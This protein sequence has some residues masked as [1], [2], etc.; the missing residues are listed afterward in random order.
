MPG[1]PRR[2]NRRTVLRPRK[3]AE[4]GGFVKTI[5]LTI[6][7]DGTDFFGFQKQTGRE[8]TMPTVQACIEAVFERVAGRR[9]DSKGS[10]RTDRGV[11]AL[12]QVVS[13]QIADGY[14]WRIPA[15]GLK[16]LM[17]KGLPPSIRVRSVDIHDGKFHALGNALGKSYVYLVNYGEPSVFLNRFSWHVR[18]PIDFSRLASVVRWFRGERDWSPFCDGELTRED[19]DDLVKDIKLFKFRNIPSRRLILFHAEADGFLY[20]MV[21]RM[22]G[23]SIDYATGR[24]DEAS[25][26]AIFTDT[27][28]RS[29]Y[30][31]APS[32]GLFLY[33]VKYDPSFFA[34]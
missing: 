8:D 29:D 23:F 19:P 2:R 6:E 25:A 32:N 20:R 22:V 1:R 13:I 5:I 26:R 31:A 21:R 3:V 11:H 17:N 4:N 7:Y 34:G 15:F 33:R 10:G 30:A 16:R 28:R 24:F 14:D 18:K 27:A 9:F 12:G